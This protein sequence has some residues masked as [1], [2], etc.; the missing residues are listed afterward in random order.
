M[1]GHLADEIAWR[2]RE[3]GARTIARFLAVVVAAIVTVACLPLVA[4]TIGAAVSRGLVDDVAPVTSFDGCAA[5]NSRFARGVGT[6]AAVDGMGWDRQ[7][8]TV[9]DRT[10]EANARLDTDRDGIACE[11]GQ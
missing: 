7:L 11:R 10:Y 2:Q 6:V 5:L 9:D 4:S 8:P 1:A 3:R